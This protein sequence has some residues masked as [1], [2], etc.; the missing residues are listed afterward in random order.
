MAKNVKT[1]GKESPN[2][3]PAR[4]AKKATK[5]QGGFKDKAIKGKR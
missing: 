4:D 3:A 2:K 1:G 5:G